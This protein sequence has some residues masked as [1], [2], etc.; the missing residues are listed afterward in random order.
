MSALSVEQGDGLKQQGPDVGSRR[1]SM[2]RGKK[3]AE[4]ETMVGK[5][6]GVGGKRGRSVATA[7][8]HYW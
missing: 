1:Q 4:R 8:V 2:E 7:D 6:H 5:E 3:W